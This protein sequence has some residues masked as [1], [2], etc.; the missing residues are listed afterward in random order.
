MAKT[1]KEIRDIMKKLVEN[2]QTN[3]TY[4]VIL[5]SSTRNSK[6]EQFYLSAD[7]TK[8]YTNDQNQ[9]KTFNTKE[10]AKKEYEDFITNLRKFGMKSNSNYTFDAMIVDQNG[11]LIA[12]HYGI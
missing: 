4:F 3:K 8:L 5:K 7:P 1:L 11:D 12:A 9:A 6:P 2:V 10:E